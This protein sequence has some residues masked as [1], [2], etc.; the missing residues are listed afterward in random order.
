VQERAGNTLEA[1][2]ISKDF[3]GRTPAVQQLRERTDKWD[4][5]KSNSFCTTRKLSLNRRDYQQSGRKYL[6]TIHQ[7]IVYRL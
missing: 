1:T 4:Y 5:M 2:V 6:L 3:L 7:C